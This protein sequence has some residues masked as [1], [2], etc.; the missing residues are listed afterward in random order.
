MVN[1]YLDQAETNVIVGSNIVNCQ[2]AIM[3]TSA[4]KLFFTFILFI[5]LVTTKVFAQSDS[6]VL[7]DITWDERSPAGMTELFIPSKRPDE[8]VAIQ[9]GLMLSDNFPAAMVPAG[10]IPATFIHQH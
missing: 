9:Y 8:Q 10:E 2:A 6:I 1:P 4:A 7:K 5:S 3:Y